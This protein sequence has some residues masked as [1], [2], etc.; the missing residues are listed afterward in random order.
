MIFLDK[1]LRTHAVNTKSYIRDAAD[2][3]CKLQDVTIPM[4][5]KLV[6][7]DGTSLYTSISHEL[8]VPC[9]TKALDKMFLMTGCKEFLIGL[10]EIV[11]TCNY[12]RFDGNYYIQIRGTTMG[13]NMAPTY[14][15]M[16]MASL[17]RLSYSGGDT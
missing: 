12:F 14:A 9:V 16:V 6:S 5:A 7:F 1:I 3:L 13:S 17:V 15:N 11:L 8:G 10:F 4:G 2:F